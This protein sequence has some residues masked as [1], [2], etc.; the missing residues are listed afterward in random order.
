[1]IQYIPKALW[2]YL[3]GIKNIM[4]KFESGK[5]RRITP[6]MTVLNV[7]DR[8]RETEVVSRKYDEQAGICICCQAL[9]D[10]LK[11]VSEKYGIDL[12]RLMADLKSEI[13]S[14]SISQ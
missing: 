7:I 3:K 1:M 8:Y 6:D 14:I 12:K 4:S 5:D 13:D 10:T 2:I 11:G 9:F